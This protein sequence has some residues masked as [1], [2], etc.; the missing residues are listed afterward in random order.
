M[1]ELFLRS[2]MA[3]RFLSSL[4]R[5]DGQKDSGSSVKR[6]YASLPSDIE[7]DGRSGTYREVSPRLIEEKLDQTSF[8]ESFPGA[9]SSFAAQVL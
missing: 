6:P 3:L 4:S 9:R 5:R 8:Q 7:R 2:E 1:G